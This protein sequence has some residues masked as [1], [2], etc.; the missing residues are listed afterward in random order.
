M[1]LSKDVTDKRQ[2]DDRR[3]LLDGISALQRNR[4]DR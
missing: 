4:S 3:R 1:K 2:Y